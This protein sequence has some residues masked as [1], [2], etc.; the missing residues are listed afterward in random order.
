MAESGTTEGRT[1]WLGLLKVQIVCLLWKGNPWEALTLTYCFDSLFFKDK[2]CWWGWKL[3]SLSYTFLCFHLHLKGSPRPARDVPNKLCTEKSWRWILTLFVQPVGRVLEKNAFRYRWEP[4]FSLSFLM[5]IN[6]FT[7]E[8]TETGPPPVH[9]S[10]FDIALKNAFV[11]KL[12]WSM[13]RS[14]FP[15]RT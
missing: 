9:V 11:G 12:Y 7:N 2:G 10:P 6:T 13:P 3:K 8:K 5:Y 14:Y 15:W 4:F 1:P